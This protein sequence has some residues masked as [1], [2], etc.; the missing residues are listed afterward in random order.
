MSDLEQQHYSE[1]VGIHGNGVETKSKNDDDYSF[2]GCSAVYFSRSKPRM[3]VSVQPPSEAVRSLERRYTSTT[4]GY[5]PESCNLYTCR[6]D[7]MK[8]HIEN[9]IQLLYSEVI[10]LK[11]AEFYQYETLIFTRTSLRCYNL[12]SNLDICTTVKISNCI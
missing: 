1:T 4:R 6:R 2:L 5:I 9:I 7:N 11:L 12:N 8:S 10:N 3:Q